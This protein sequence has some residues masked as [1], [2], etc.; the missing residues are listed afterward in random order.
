MASNDPVVLVPYDEVWPALFEAERARIERAI[1][2]WTEEIEHIGSTAV[3]GLAAKPI[4]DVMVG[5]RSLDASPLLVERLEV[6]GYEYVPEFERELP[7]RRFFRK[8][9]DG[10]RTHQIHLVE[11]T[12]TAW[13]DRHLLF[14][15][16]LR[17][18]PEVAD[19]YA[20]LKRGLSE[21]FREDRE[22]YAEAKTGFV[23]RILRRAE[24]GKGVG[25]R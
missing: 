4:I 18:R 15:D 2:P 10:L 1:G 16:Y 12:N 8:L 23:D 6:L 9:R 25:S 11:R 22:A 5:V 13:W 19:E 3:P 20:V 17:A 24:E 21:R 14:R 7:H